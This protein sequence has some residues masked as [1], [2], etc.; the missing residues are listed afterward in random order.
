MRR[1]RLT[2]ESRYGYPLREALCAEAWW[3][4]EHLGRY[5]GGNGGLFGAI[6]RLGYRQRKKWERRGHAA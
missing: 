3:R 4:V 1:P 6:G 5:R 2:Y